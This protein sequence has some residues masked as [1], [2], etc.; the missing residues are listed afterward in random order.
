M[1]AP[2]HIREAPGKPGAPPRWSR[3]NKHAGGT[4][5][6]A[7]CLVWFTIGRGVLNEVYYPRID[8]PCTRDLYLIVTGPNGFVS[9]ERVDAEH[10]VEWL[11][12]GVP[13]FK[14]TTEC[15][16]GRYRVEKIFITDDRL[17]VVLENVRFTHLAS[18]H[19]LFV[20]CNPHLAAHGDGNTA[21]IGRYKGRNVLCAQR[22][23]LSLGLL[24]SEEYLA[25]SVGFAD[26]SDGLE[27]LKKYGRLVETFTRATDGNVGLIGEVNL[28]ANKQFTIALAFGLGAPDAAYH[29]IGGLQCDFNSTKQLYIARWQRWQ[30]Q[31]LPLDAVPHG[32]NL[33]R[34]S[35]A[36]LMSHTNKSIPGA[37]A[38][39]SIPWGDSRGDEDLLQ[40]AYHLVWSRDLVQHGGGLLAVG[41]HE[42]A[43][44]LLDYLR[45]TQEPYGHWPQNMWVSGEPFWDG[46]QVDQAA[47]PILL[48]DHALREGAIADSDRKQYWPMLRRAAGFI[49]RNGAS[50]ELDRW[51]EQK[52]YNTFTLSV[53]ITSLLAAADWADV[54]EE[55]DLACYLRETAAIWNACIEGWL[56]VRGSKLANQIGVDGY[57]ARILPPNSIEPP[58]A[59]QQYVQLINSDAGDQDL[60]AHE[61]V[62]IDALALVRFGLRA[63]DDPKIRNTL[64]A[65]D[66]TLQL[67]MEQGPIWHR[68]NCDRFGEHDDGAPFEA[69]NKGKG[70]AWPLL[71]GER[72]HFELASG[73]DQRVNELMAAMS[74]YAGEAGLISEQVWDAEDI[75]ERQLFRG[76]PTGSASPLL[77]AHSE[78]LKLLRSVKD[79]VVFDRPPQM[80]ARSESQTSII[81]SLWR[82]EHPVRTIP[83]G[84]ALRIEAV[85]GI[86]IE[87]QIEGGERHS[88]ADAASFLD[89]RVADLPVESLPQGTR[90]HI[91]AT[92]TLKDGSI[93]QKKHRVEVR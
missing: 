21:W 91:S 51:E 44:R 53:M 82:I 19:S 93:Q 46:V 80:A 34:A 58:H 15:K 65:I 71:I 75:P 89:V 13:G 35:T 79:G 33:F 42:D 70:R 69:H 76:R 66:A 62:S 49:V 20:Y 6:S 43:K 72:A 32:R 64:K 5:R 1:H 87:W 55:T 23:D 63:P 39:L 74:A 45:V 37:V 41:A 36:I 2:E 22:G 88:L 84:T 68:Y 56:Y 60:P 30:D 12:D 92:T 8:T 7:S 78:Y 27:D 16:L 73:N 47:Q 3:G 85:E 38:S 52:G 57:Y 31:L 86:E 54:E 26:K 77:W 14:V 17:D 29:A 4:C 10:T 59:N 67:Q 90:V 9:D 81:R 48:T 40:G 83:Y 18:G 61:V 11:A 24:C 28:P 25:A 50:T